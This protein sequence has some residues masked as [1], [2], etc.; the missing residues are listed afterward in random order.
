MLNST[1]K[2][3][4]VNLDSFDSNRKVRVSPHAEKAKK[5]Y[6]WF[7]LDSLGRGGSVGRSV[8]RIFILF[9]VQ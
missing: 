1:K 4:E 9:F 3:I 8:G 6:V 2:K 5:I 7:L